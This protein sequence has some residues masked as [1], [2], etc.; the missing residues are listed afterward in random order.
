M[1]RNGRKNAGK[2]R[3]AAGKLW[4]IMGGDYRGRSYA[5]LESSPEE[6]LFE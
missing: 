2:L 6:A 4:K 1:P 3:V 5:W